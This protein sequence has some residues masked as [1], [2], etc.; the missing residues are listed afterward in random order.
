MPDAAL[1]G[2]VV[3]RIESHP[4]G[5]GAADLVLAAFQDADLV[6]AVLR[7][8]PA[9]VLKSETH[10]GVAAPS[11]AVFLTAI[12]VEGFRGI[13]PPTTLAIDPGPG[14]TLVVGRNG[15]GKSSFSEALEMT[16]LGTNQ[17][18]DQRVKVWRDGWQNLHHR[19]TRVAARFVVDRR[20]QPIDVARVW[21]EG[22]GVDGSTLT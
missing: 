11:A 8:E 3:D 14:L 10:A 16:L 17:R 13:G 2:L 9:A 15:S 4:P 6:D 18:W 19:H 7:G 5:A 22:D 12:E 1:L 20:K 21:K